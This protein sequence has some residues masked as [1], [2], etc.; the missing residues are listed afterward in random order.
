[1]IEL[2]A[3]VDWGKAFVKATYNLEGNGLLSLTCYETIKEAISSMQVK[4]IPN[5]QAV[6]NDISS[7]TTVQQQLVAYTKNCVEPALHYFRQR[8]TSSLNAPLAAF[9]AFKPK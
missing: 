3:V 1:M 8:L 9:K 7:T 6:A 2:V 4:N 5:V